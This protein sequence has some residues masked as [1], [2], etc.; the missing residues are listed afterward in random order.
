MAFDVKKINPLDL[1]PRKAVGINI[2]FTGAA[3]FNSTYQS[4]DSIKANLIN[5]F[6]TGRGERLYRPTFGSG[7]HDLLFENINEDAMGKV[8][9]FI[10]EGLQLYFPR[11]QVIELNVI[12]DPDFNKINFY[13]KYAIAQTNI[14][15]QLLINFQQ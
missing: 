6:L 10:R 4:K 8:E 12:G 15:D 2:P 11:V 9:A 1:Q 3:V 5:F 14:E 13:L 7:L